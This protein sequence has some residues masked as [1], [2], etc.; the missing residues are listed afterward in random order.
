M[1]TEISQAAGQS[2]EPEPA[3]TFYY[4]PSSF[5]R[6]M[7]AVAW[8]AFAHPFSHT[9]IDRETSEMCHYTRDDEIALGSVQGNLPS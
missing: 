7:F 9:W 5:F 3:K 1:A 4:S 8:S 2:R 6:A